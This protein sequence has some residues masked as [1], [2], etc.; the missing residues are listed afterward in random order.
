MIFLEQDEFTEEEARVFVE[1]YGIKDAPL[2]ETIVEP[3]VST[4]KSPK[5]RA[6]YI[7][8]GEEFLQA[9]SEMLSRE[10][11]TKAVSFPRMY[12]DNIFKMFGFEKKSFQ[13]NLKVILKNVSDKTEFQTIVAN[14]TNVIHAIVLVYADSIQHRA[15]RDSARQQMGLSIYNN[16][17]NSFF[18]PPHPVE[19]T[20]AYTYMNLDNSW[21][22]VK[23][24]NIINW[25]DLTI[26]TAFQFWRSRL[27]IEM[28][29]SVLVQFLNRVRTSFRQNLRLL[30]NQYFKTVEENKGNLVGT[31]V[32]S[33]DLYFETNNTVKLRDGLIR[34]INSKD[35]LYCNKGDLYTGI[36]KLKNVKVDTLYEFAQS[37]QQADI[38]NIIDVI[39]YV[40]ISKEGN[41]IDDINSV[42]YISRITNLPTAIDRAVAGKPII[43]T[44]AK[45][46]KVDQSIVRAYVC[47]VA[48]YIMYRINDVR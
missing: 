13:E 17:F 14:P 45:K 34:R 8:Y 39:F 42:K 33:D 43:E 12:V 47:L 3:I 25:I 26:E 11:P 15:L 36:A 5:R 7:R 24:E 38:A 16:N 1:A 32:S 19:S 31:D 40:F 27:D 20:M 35:Q 37:I 22:L 44:L 21:N 46:Y 10:F 2:N 48:T 41:S 6:E 4:I 30:A 9:N 29:T 23:C 18:H 28:D